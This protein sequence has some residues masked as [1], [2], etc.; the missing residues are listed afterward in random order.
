MIHLIIADDEKI[1]RDSLLEFIPWAELGIDSV[2]TAKNG[3]AAWELCKET[4]PDILLTDVRMPKM[5]GIQL[6]QKVREHYPECKIIFLSGYADKE[7]LKQAVH[8]Q[9]VS[10]IEKPVNNDELIPV[11]K[12]AVS[13]YHE[14]EQ[15]KRQQ[16]SLQNKLSENIP[17][18]RQ[19][20]ALELVQGENLKDL[21]SRYNDE[22]ILNLDKS[23]C[24]CASY[25][26]FN[27]KS[28]VEEIQMARLKK[29]ILFLVNKHENFAPACSICGFDEKGNLILILAKHSENFSQELDKLYCFLNDYF[30]RQ[31][32]ISVSITI[33]A[34]D[35]VS[36]AYRLSESFITAVDAAASQFYMGSGRI[37]YSKISENTKFEVDKN[38][39][40]SFRESLL[41]NKVNRA[42]QILS[43]L[44][45]KIRSSKD[46][47]VNY[48]KNIYFNLILILYEAAFDKEIFHQ[49]EQTF[50]W[51]EINQFHT[52]SEL[53]E[54]VDRHITH[55]FYYMNEL[56]ASNKKVVEI[57][58]IIRENLSNPNL[59]VNY[60]ADRC[61]FSQTYL[62]AFFKKNT[63]KTLN[64]FITIER[65]EKAKKLLKNNN[66]KLY[67]VATSIGLSDP[68]YFSRLFKK[69]V[70]LTPSEF[71]ERS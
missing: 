55:Y 52:L 71:R 41:K 12:K 3:I 4:K 23:Y 45:L 37:Y 14:N 66:M 67:E 47:N 8:L 1:T 21:F 25:T 18:I 59:S 50:V 30:S 40:P 31:P 70:G 44:T 7:Y 19:E 68:N 39:Y 36:D 51:Q 32:D 43:E 9:A 33:G 63:G 26:V 46:S 49:N 2:K 48:I 6:A 24:Y 35:I 15:K 29:D 53:H 42:H 69:Y 61:Y 27:W 62:C 5:D 60:I 10:Y 58:D 54:Y 17:L 57:M 20:I 28:H 34:G 38:L 65:I 16:E 22:K 11:I 64:E 13:Q 56:D